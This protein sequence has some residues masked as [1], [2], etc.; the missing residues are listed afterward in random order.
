VRC[1]TE[2]V[3]ESSPPGVTLSESNAPLLTFE[4]AVERVM[5]SLHASRDFEPHV[6]AANRQ[7]N[8]WMNRSIADLH[9]MR[10]NTAYGPYPYAGVPWFSTVFGRDGIISALECL[11]FD[12]GMARGVLSYLAATQSNETIPE[13]DSQPGK[14]LHEARGGEMAALGEVPYSRYYGSTDA[15]PLFV[16][17]ADAYLER[18]GDLEFTTSI[19][20]NVQRALM[21]IDTHGDIDGD[22]F[23]EYARRTPRGLLN[24]GWKDSH[25]AVFHAN[26]DVPD[27]PIALC[28]VQGYVYAA[29][30]AAATLARRL[31]DR[32]AADTLTAQ[33]EEIRL[34][35]EEKFWSD[36]LGTYVF[37][38]DGEKRRC[39]VRTSNAGHCLWTGIASPERAARVAATLLD[40]TSFSGWGIR[41]VASG[42]PRYN[43]MAYH[44][45]SIWPHD[46]A[47]IAAGF[48]RYGLMKEA[49]VVF[50]ALYD[51]SLFFDLHRL[52]ELF[53]GFKRRPGESPTHYPV[54]C[55]PQTWA[56]ASVF[57]FLQSMFGLTVRGAESEVV[58]ARPALPAFLPEVRLTGLRVGDGRL[59]LQ[60]N[61]HEYDVSV[62]VL[63]RD[64]DIRVVVMK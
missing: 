6:W 54:S 36:E 48:A 50:N 34:A 20:P 24:Q 46:N 35:F 57:M 42:I 55:S 49:E 61:R 59:D 22:G 9:M 1:A 27:G 15:T 23:V 56:S 33:A 19:W 51:A 63:E 11:W 10:T 45:G 26:G 31:G 17:L 25:D 38:L 8:E 30:R 39:E 53:C 28:E 47:I 18:S 29:R 2:T 60:L 5:E 14:I 44:N 52:P 7:F 40:E 58:F 64:G 4:K 43:P 12:P 32:T 41:T 3:P 21:W 37:A 62:N 13:K 16:I